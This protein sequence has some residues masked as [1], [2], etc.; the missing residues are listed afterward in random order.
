MGDEGA[1]LAAVLLAGDLG[2]GVDQI[3][4][5]GVEGRLQPDGSI[6]ST[7]GTPAT[8]DYGPSGILDDDVTGDAS[9]AVGFRSP[10]GRMPLTAFMDQFNQLV[11]GSAGA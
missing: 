2:Y 4:P 8:P 6:S 3:V 1:A 5:A 10:P 11:G 7:D 9:E